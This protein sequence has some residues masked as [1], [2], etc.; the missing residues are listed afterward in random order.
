MGRQL[1][2][3]PLDAV[4]D[5]VVR[6]HA[7]LEAVRDHSRPHGIGWPAFDGACLEPAE[8]FTFGDTARVHLVA[9][10]EVAEGRL[11]HGVVVSLASVCAFIARKA[12]AARWRYVRQ[13]S[14]VLSR[15]AGLARYR[16]VAAVAFSR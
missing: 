13:A 15:P 5:A 1:L 14:R 8:T 3:S 6:D 10:H 9:F 7:T 11:L 12:A 16:R 2:R 4:V